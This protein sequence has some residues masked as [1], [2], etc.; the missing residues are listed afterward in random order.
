MMTV[1]NEADYNSWRFQKDAIH[2]NGGAVFFGYGHRCVTQPRLLVIDKYFRKDR[3][4]QRSYLIDGK[5]PFTTLPEALAALEKPPTLSDD[6]L[7]LLRALPEGWS[8]PEKRGD[9]V[10]L[11]DMGLIEWRRDDNG[12]ACQRTDS[13]NA[14]AIN[15]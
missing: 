13:G 6:E 1:Y 14:A 12:V 11:A 5:L 8:Y 2:Y 3:S 15:G 4:A 10:P 7:R 9:L